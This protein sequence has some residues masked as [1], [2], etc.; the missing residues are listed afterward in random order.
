[1]P[2]LSEYRRRPIAPVMAVLAIGILAVAVYV[3]L[4]TRAEQV[5]YVVIK[6]YATLVAVVA[7]VRLRGRE[8]TA[9]LMIAGGLG[10]FAVADG[11]F[12]ATQLITGQ[13]TPVPS[14]ADLVYLVGYPLIVVG[15]LMFVTRSGMHLG[16]AA[17]LE[18]AV[19]VI[20]AAILQWA[21]IGRDSHSALGA[22]V[23]FAYAVGDALLIALVVRGFVDSARR[24][25]ATVLLLAGAMFQLVADLLYSANFATYETGAWYDGLWL[26]A[27]VLLAAAIVSVVGAGERQTELRSDLSRQAPIGFV[28]M[29]GVAM[30][31]VPVALL[32]WFAGHQHVS[33]SA[34][35]LLA[36]AAIVLAALV[37]ARLV[38][39][40]RAVN[41]AQARETSTRMR[42]EQ[43]LA[44][45]GSLLA[46]MQSGVVVEDADRR[47]V[48]I[49][50]Q[51]CDIVG[52]DGPPDDLVGADCD[53]VIAAATACPVD[54]A[55]VHGLA[56]ARMTGR[57]PAIADVIQFTDGRVIERDYVPIDVGGSSAG[58]MWLYRDATD[59][60]ALA[61]SLQVSQAR[62]ASTIATALDAVIWM[63]SHGTVVEFNP[64]AEAMFGITR[65]RAVGQ[66]LG[67][68]IIPEGMREAHSRGH[69]R[70]TSGGS[71]AIVGAR[72][73]LVAKHADGHEFPIEMAVSVIDGESPVLYTA[74]LRNITER[75]RIERDL[76]T[77]RD[78]A[79]RAA[80]LKSEFLATMSHEIRTPMYGVVGTLDL[81][82]RTSLD[83]D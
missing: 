59:Q 79:I 39:L 28:V 64:A 82:R 83:D 23:L 48:L 72:L 53:A 67:E 65:E 46:G 80:E 31:V 78:E 43:A 42:A 56:G 73:E 17:A 18:T 35:M 36:S 62:N 7:A 14:V 21:L 6:A 25:V 8:R 68:L 54:G 20:A 41:A 57:M 58:S 50:Q 22:V 9:G 10:A 61:K 69:A 1:M 76:A 77:A 33:R 66:A 55:G 12:N 75:Q 24:R 11:L 74:F 81:L 2:I 16:G 44:R 27:A 13:P 15:A 30:V 71:S 49:N 51:F 40:L 5:W 47:I 3:L 60:V 19:V 4:P 52:I 70:V 29:L 63:D 32:V 38:L 26:G 37:V 34:D 45:L